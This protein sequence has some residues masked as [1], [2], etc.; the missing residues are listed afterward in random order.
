MHNS[1]L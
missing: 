1:W